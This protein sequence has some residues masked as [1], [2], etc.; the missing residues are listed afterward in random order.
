M[1]KPLARLW[2][3]WEDNIRVD[4][5]GRLWWWELVELAQDRVQC[6]A[7]LNHWVSLPHSQIVVGSSA[8]ITPV[9]VV[10]C[11]CP[12]VTTQPFYPLGKKPQY[13]LDRRAA[14]APDS[15]WTLWTRI[16]LTPARNRTAI[17]SPLARHCADWFI[18]ASVDIG[19]CY[20]NRPTHCSFG[21]S[22]KTVMD[23]TDNLHIPWAYVALKIRSWKS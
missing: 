14:W 19:T 10:M 20:L 3:R 5:G 22:R 16:Y 8:N 21:W 11:I 1:T 17:P 6:V 23:T 15:V 13:Q 7:M 9:S 2:T 12:H 4:L 18:P